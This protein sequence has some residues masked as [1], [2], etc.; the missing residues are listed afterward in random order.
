M[1]VT[2]TLVPFSRKTCVI[3]IFRPI[4][5]IIV[6]SS[7]PLELDLDIDAG[8]QIELHQRLDESAG[9]TA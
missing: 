8:R 3:P 5:P 6:L 7:G 9:T 1:T 4:M 2:G